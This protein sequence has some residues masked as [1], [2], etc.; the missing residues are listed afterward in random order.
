MLNYTH[1]EHFQHV[2]AYR[3]KFD[4]FTK[5]ANV[6]ELYQ[7]NILQFRIFG[8]LRSENSLKRRNNDDDDEWRERHFLLSI[9]SLHF[10][11]FLN[12]LFSC[13]KLTFLLIYYSLHVRN[14]RLMKQQQRSRSILLKKKNESLVSFSSTSSLSGSEEML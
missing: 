7:Q 1:L 12:L 9:S 11:L 5:E 8:H 14:L 6:T 10:F 4:E 3:R 2:L 13:A